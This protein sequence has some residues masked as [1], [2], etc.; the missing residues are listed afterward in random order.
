M[1]I[2][3]DEPT[4]DEKKNL[5]ENCE[6]YAAQIR[7]NKNPGY[8]YT[9]S[10]GMMADMYISLKDYGKSESEIS[11]LPYGRYTQARMRGMLEYYKKQYSESR[12]HFHESISDFLVWLFWDMNMLALTYKHEDRKM[13]DKIYQ[14]EYNVIHSIYNDE[15]YPIPLQDYLKNAVRRLAQRATWDDDKNLAFKYLDEFMSVLCEQRK[16]YNNK[17]TTDSILLP[18]AK[19]PYNK[20]QINKHF[21]GKSY[22]LGTFEWHAFDRIRDEEHFKAYIEEVK[23]WD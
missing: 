13:M 21:S 1:I 12:S 4:E 8:L 19:P 9:N 15:K 23:A 20:P 2:K 16:C 22:A 11:M 3:K 7:E 10:Y 6:R 18:E 14:V 17:F 5:V